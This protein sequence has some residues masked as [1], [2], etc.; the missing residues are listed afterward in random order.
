MMKPQ[1]SNQ[2]PFA[3]P[4]AILGIAPTLDL[5]A[6]KRAYFAALAKHPPHSDPDGFKQ[7]RSAYEALGSRGDAA[8][9]LLRSAIDV[10]FELSVLR[11]RHDAALAGARQA[12]AASAADSARVARFT[13][14][15]ANLSF[16]EA[17]DVFGG[18]RA[19][20]GHDGRQP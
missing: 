2:S 12:S 3:S 7:I 1:R 13:E 15:L 9:L 20:Q 8:S 17:L 6:I 5:R 4:F 10:E 11:E 14:G 19:G 18:V 16:E